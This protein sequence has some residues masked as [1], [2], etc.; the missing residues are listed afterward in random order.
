[1]IAIIRTAEPAALKNYATKWLADLKAILADP[2]A[3]PAQRT[4]AINRY[5]HRDAKN[6]LVQLFH[7]KCAYCE[8]RV[9][10]V[11]YGAIEHFYPKSRYVE[12][13]FDWRNLLLSCDI[14]NDKGHKGD[15]FP[16]D[17]MG[18]PLFIDPTDGITDISAHLGF[19]WDSAAGSAV[20]YGLD[21]R[22]R[23][24]EDIFDL[25]GLRGR[26]ELLRHRSRYVRQLT[27]LCIFAK[28]NNAEAL[29]LLREACGPEAEYSA[30]ALSVCKAI[31]G[32][33]P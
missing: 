9:T 1:M 13:V 5:R 24:I 11:T 29:Q 14:C 20:V 27:A 30:F 4:K 2:A 15:R 21:A 31:L 10:V 17:D 25:N 33:L 32:K 7:G 18:Q 12:R 22:G 19:V 8:S 28:D 23:L 6:A 3:S 26:M 16:L